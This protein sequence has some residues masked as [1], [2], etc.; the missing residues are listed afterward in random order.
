MNESIRTDLREF[1]NRMEKE[2]PGIKNNAYASMMKV[3][4]KLRMSA[5]PR[6][7]KKCTICGRDATGE[8]CS[9]CKTAQ[10]LGR[11]RKLI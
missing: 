2:H 8:V 11:N 5:E 7:D 3:S 9:V 10:V 6:G 1:F 4:E